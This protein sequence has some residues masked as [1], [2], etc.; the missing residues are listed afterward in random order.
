M[1]CTFCNGVKKGVSLGAITVIHRGM[2]CVT[3]V[4]DCSVSGQWLSL[5]YT[6]KCSSCIGH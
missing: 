2:N 5:C 3:Q 4:S 1:I 6:L